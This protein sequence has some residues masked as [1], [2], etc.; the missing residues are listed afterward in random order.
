M[1]ITV[2]SYWTFWRNEQNVTW[3][4]LGEEKIGIGT[5]EM[6]A[7]SGRFDFHLPAPRSVLFLEVSVGL[8]L[9]WMQLM[10]I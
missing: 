8:D 1:K 10:L 9:H 6:K 7:Y 4:Q 3:F 5:E 2:C